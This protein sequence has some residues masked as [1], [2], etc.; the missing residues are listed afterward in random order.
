MKYIACLL[1][2]VLVLKYQD[3]IHKTKWACATAGQDWSLI[4][5]AVWGAFVAMAICLG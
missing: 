3:Q 1:A 2:C 5:G 4:L